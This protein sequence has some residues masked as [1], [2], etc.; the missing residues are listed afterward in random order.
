M[1]VPSLGFC[2]L[3][4]FLISKIFSTSSTKKTFTN[5]NSFL[6]ENTKPLV[7]VGLIIILFGIQTTARNAEWKNNLT[8]YTNDA[9]KTPDSAHMLFYYTNN[10][11]NKDSLNAIKNPVEREKR[12]LTAQ[13]SITKALQLYELF[14]DAHNVAGRIYY[15]QKNYEAAF[16]SYSRAMEM[17][18][19]KGMYH[20]NAGTCLFSIGNYEEAAN[21][22]L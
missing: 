8:L 10:L 6:S 7:V 17:N 19:G 22:L 9:K 1:F 14:P 3:I 18:P 5:I 21:A 12:L 2:I 20:N 4:A 15:E 11:A 13:K 16:K